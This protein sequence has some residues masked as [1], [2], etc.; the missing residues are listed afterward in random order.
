MPGPKGGGGD[1]D[2]D[3][4]SSCLLITAVAGTCRSLKERPWG[5]LLGPAAVCQSAVGQ[6]GALIFRKCNVIPVLR[7]RALGSGLV[8]FKLRGRIW[9]FVWA[10]AFY[11]WMDV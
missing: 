8:Q 9:T 10:K 5:V 6:E 3:D 1:D 4:G 11:I 7:I 2:D